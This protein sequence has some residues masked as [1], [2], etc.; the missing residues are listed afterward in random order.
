MAR[1]T[2]SFLTLDHKRSRLFRAED[3]RL[4]SCPFHVCESLYHPQSVFEQSLASFRPEQVPQKEAT[5]SS[6]FRDS[7]PEEVSSILAAAVPYLQLIKIIITRTEL[8]NV[9]LSN[10]A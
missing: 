9:T 2:I 7:A 3:K 8:G 6:P 4:L 10:A 5:F 1:A